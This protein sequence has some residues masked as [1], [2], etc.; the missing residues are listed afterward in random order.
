MFQN[1]KIY[2][3]YKSQGVWVELEVGMC[4]PDN[5]GQNIVEKFRT[6]DKKGFSIKCFMDGFWQFFS[7]TV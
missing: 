6:V 5:L 2:Q 4:L 3:I 7:T 1:T